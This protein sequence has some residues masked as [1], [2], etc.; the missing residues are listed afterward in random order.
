M[1][2]VILLKG[3][4]GSGKTTW[5]LGRV[6][7]NPNSYKRVNKDDIRAMMDAGL[8]SSDMERQVLNVRDHLIMLAIK[9]GKH[10]I[11]DDTN[12]NPIHQEHITKLIRPIPLAIKFFDTPLDEC[13]ENDLKRV[14]SVGSK[15][16]KR[17][18]NQWLAK[19]DEKYEHVIGLPYAIICDIDGTVAKHDG[20]RG[21]YEYERVG[22]DTPNT[23]I[24]ELVRKFHYAGTTEILYVSGRPE[25]AR[26]DTDLWLTKHGLFTGY[27][28]MRPNG[29]NR[30]DSIVKSEIFEQFIR[31]FWNIQMVFDDRDRVVEMWRKKGLT[32]LQV[33]RGDF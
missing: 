5:A 11:I 32:C 14:K 9:E 10:V 17:M 21:H 22:L 4:P 19:P 33:D 27:L 7:A 8:H 26:A 29:D 28:F 20:I 3:L 16:I 18:H 23:P 15:V 6:K 2:Q 31:P 1:K 30:E 24:I 12:L 25:S 13:I